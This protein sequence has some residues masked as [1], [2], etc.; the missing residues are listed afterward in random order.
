MSVMVDDERC[1]RCA[2]CSGVC[3]VGAISIG[4]RWQVDEDLCEGC[5]LC[6][7]VC[8]CSAVMEVQDD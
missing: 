2:V 6:I 7:K 4:W 3:P 1:Y 8:P 5:G